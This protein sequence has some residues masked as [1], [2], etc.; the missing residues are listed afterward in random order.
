MTIKYIKAIERRDGFC[1]DCICND[2]EGY[3]VQ[4][5]IY[6]KPIRY[7]D[8]EYKSYC[9]YHMT[10]EQYIALIDSLENDL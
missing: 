5:W 2:S 4:C 8:H 3:Y 9:N 1:D 6:K 10:S 7:P